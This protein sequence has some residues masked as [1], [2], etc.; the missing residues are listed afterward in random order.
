MAA[1]QLNTYINFKDNAREAFT[2][3]QSVLGGKLE[4]NTF[5][6]FHAMDD[7]AEQ[8]NIMHAK[9]TLDSGEAIMGADT[10]RSMEFR[11][12]WGFSVSLSG[13]NAEELHRYFAG[14]SEGGAVLMPLEKQMWGDEFGMVK[15]KFD[16]AWM[17]NISTPSTENTAV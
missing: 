11:E 10:S 16:V 14:L 15:D 7:P 4:L 8:D 13:D 9:L 3:Y 1:T 17:V 6:E 12:P 5:G 2:F